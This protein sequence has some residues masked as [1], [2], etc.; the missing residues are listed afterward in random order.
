[1]DASLEIGCWVESEMQY[2]DFNDKRLKNRSIKVLRSLSES[3]QSSIPDSHK[4][5]S[6]TFA[7][8]RFFEN[9]K[10][11]HEKVLESH[12]QST[13]R[14]SADHSIILAIQDTS[15]LNF[16]GLRKSQGLGYIGD[17]KKNPHAKGLFFH[18]TYAL[19]PE[20]RIPLGIVHQEIWDRGPSKKKTSYELETMPIL[21]KE[22]GKWIRAMVSVAEKTKT[23][24]H[25][26]VVHVMDR[27]GDIY[28]VFSEAQHLDQS[29][30]I[31]AKYDRR[32]NKVSKGSHRCEKLF[33]NLSQQKP[34]GTIDI[35]VSDRSG[36][37]VKRTATVE[38]K[39]M[40]FIASPRRS[41]PNDPVRFKASSVNLTI[42]SCREIFQENEGEDVDEPIDWMLL[43]NVEVNSVEQILTCVDYYCCR[44]QI[45]VFHRILKTGCKIEECR[46]S[47]AKRIKTM[48]A[49]LSIVAWRIHWLTLFSR[50]E[51][52]SSADLVFTPAEHTLLLKLTLKKKKKKKLML[53]ES[54][55]L[56][57]QLGGFLNR[58]HDRNP[59]PEVIWRGLSRFNDIIKTLET[60]G[61]AL[62]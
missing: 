36:L 8:H 19:Q 23:L 53:G 2:A 21:E 32:I 22:S 47:E 17:D 35:E 5:W 31:R 20:G 24:P 44:W 11:S 14:R 15:S 50:K 60:L 9:E 4:D 51:P 33:S 55:R 3:P 49:I 40:K 12:I 54:V 28:E 16:S 34:I 10:V 6:E 29:F 30:I 7:A 26:K 48:V 52:T 38:L 62:C 18:T 37:G 59:G 57:A 39:S 27:E 13:L 41:Q 42:I 45:E 25:T 56:L 61:G 46:F 1:M 43:T 58:K